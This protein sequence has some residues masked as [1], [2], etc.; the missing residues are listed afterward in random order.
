M[1]IKTMI[2]H[3]LLV[4]FY[5]LSGSEI[6]AQGVVVYIKCKTIWIKNEE[7][8]FFKAICSGFNYTAKCIQSRNCMCANLRVAVKEKNIR[9]SLNYL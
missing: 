6:K 8:Q 4:D 2:T 3:P 1:E 5:T 9:L 7:K